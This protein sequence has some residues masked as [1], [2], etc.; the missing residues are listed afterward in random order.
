MNF[1]TMSLQEILFQV[2]DESKLLFYPEQWSKAFLDFSKN[3]IFTLILI[4]R[5][6]QVNMT[7]IADYL[8]VPLNT[9]TGIVSRLEKRTVIKRERDQADKRIVVVNLT[10]Y[11]RDSMKE[12]F[13]ELEYYFKI[14][15]TKL[16][17]E[18]VNL[19]LKMMN[20]IFQVLKE[21]NHSKDKNQTTEKKVKRIMIE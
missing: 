16:S 15:M 1:E 6:G 10:S 5:K 14:V 12:L 13:Q 9:V 8:N 17:P 18:E 20:Q 21:S 2:M 19:A 4:Y 7:E 3:E 11:G